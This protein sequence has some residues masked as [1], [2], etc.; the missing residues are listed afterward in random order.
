MLVPACSPEAAMRL[1]FLLA[2]AS[3]T[4]VSPLVAQHD[5]VRRP[6]LPSNADTNDA[7]AYVAWANRRDV[8][9][10]K[11]Y[12][13]YHW[14]WRLEPNVTAY[15]YA[16]YVALLNR[17]PAKWL[18]EWFRGAA[19]VTKSKEA[20][21]IDSLY[22]EVLKRDPFPHLQGPCMYPDLVEARD[23]LT[24]GFEFFLR[25]CYPQA[26]EKVAQG[27]VKDPSALGARFYRAQALF[28]TRQYKASAAEVQVILD[29]LRARDEKYVGPWYNTKEQLEYMLAVALLRARDG[30]GARAALGRALTENLAYYPAHAELAQIAMDQ[31]DIQTA[32]QEADLAVGLK[33]DDGVLRFDYGIL[34]YRAGRLEDA[35]VQLR[36]AVEREPYWAESY[37]QLA[38][39]LDHEGKAADA[40]EQYEN[41]VARAPRRLHVRAEECEARIVELRAGPG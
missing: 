5:A 4:L 29:S 6:K 7:Q 40:I 16:E 10:K 20:K 8:D 2:L 12:A 18:D 30:A 22:A 19:Y 31:R 35:E 15:R 27:T 26:A 14:A 13:A 11:A 32:L 1:P 33:E 17:Q 39:V 36:K 25:G 34:L 38:I 3:T 21:A 9:W 23:P 37:R 24:A 28:F 41:F